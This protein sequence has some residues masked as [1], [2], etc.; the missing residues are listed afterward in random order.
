M[1]GHSPTSLWP[2]TPVRLEGILS[3]YL[4]N[5]LLVLLL[6]SNSESSLHVP[7][8]NSTFLNHS[9]SISQKVQTYVKI[10]LTKRMKRRMV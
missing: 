6:R 4:K 2:T 10:R 1:M 3:S 9:S 8:T 7:D 5:D